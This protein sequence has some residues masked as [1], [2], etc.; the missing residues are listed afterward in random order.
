M[1]LFLHNPP[2]VEMDHPR[3]RK[4]ISK[5]RGPKTKR[6]FPSEVEDLSANSTVNNVPTLKDL[7]RFGKKKK[8]SNKRKRD[9]DEDPVP[10]DPT[11]SEIEE[12]KS[13]RECEWNVIGWDSRE[14]EEN[15]MLEKMDQ[16]RHRTD[17][18]ESIK[19]IW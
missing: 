10:E 18:L 8:K 15:E 14:A 1:P 3:N 13:N 5:K 2:A 4:T 12:D 19:R 7:F 16:Y 9:E 11:P 6:R 17:I